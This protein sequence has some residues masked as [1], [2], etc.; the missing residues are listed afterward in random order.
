MERES[1]A[2]PR[3]DGLPPSGDQPCSGAAFL[4]VF[5]PLCGGDH[6]DPDDPFLA[7]DCPGMPKVP[8]EL[9]L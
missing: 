1:I 9:D 5:C 3:H 7:P 8:A 2:R 6:S 4:D